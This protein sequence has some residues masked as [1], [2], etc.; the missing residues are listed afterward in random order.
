MTSTSNKSTSIRI[1]A[2][3]ETADI[4]YNLEKKRLN[5]K[6]EL[7]TVQYGNYCKN[8]YG[9]PSE[10]EVLKSEHRQALLNQC[11]EKEIAQKHA[12]RNKVKESQDAVA[13]DQS[14]QELDSKQLDTRSKYLKQFRDQNKVLMEKRSA[15][16]RKL[17]EEENRKERELLQRDPINWSKTLV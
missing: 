15:E 10:K 6:R 7:R 1:N 11:R 8:F 2:T 16:S 13:L 14:Y 5:K 17:R 4:Q 12:F 9:S 3:I